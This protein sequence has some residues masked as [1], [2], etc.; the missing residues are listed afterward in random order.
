VQ[1]LP[2]LNS[3]MYKNFEPKYRNNWGAITFSQQKAINILRANR[4]TGGPSRPSASNRD[5]WT[6]PGVGRLEFRY[7]TNLGAN[8]RRALMFQIV[9]AQLR[10]VGIQ[11]NADSVPGLQPRL[12]GSNWDI[13]N[14]AW[15]GSPTSPITY[16]NVYGC[17]RPQNF[18]NY[19]NQ[20]VS[21]LL[22]RVA[23]T[24]NDKKREALI[25]QADR[26]I[27][28]DIPTL[29]M[30]AAP[31]FAIHRTNVRSVLRNPTL[32]SL[33]WNSGTWWVQ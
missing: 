21:R 22:D 2:V 30:F 33:F 19:C 1:N 14:F 28:R 12:G 29:P 3:V 7:T 9:Q 31:G 8:A 5:I 17:G 18:K 15:V 32:A 24:V 10:S 20:R 16:N 25:Q 6:C 13:F 23:A 11:V 26:L 27:A 4:C